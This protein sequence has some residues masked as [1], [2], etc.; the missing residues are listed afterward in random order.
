LIF[1]YAAVCS[2]DPNDLIKSMLCA[3]ALR[4]QRSEQTDSSTV[5]V[6]PTLLEHPR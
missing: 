1:G 6:H 5:Q 4:N 3:R 2:L